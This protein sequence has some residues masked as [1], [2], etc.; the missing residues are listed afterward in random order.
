M[1]TQLNSNMLD[2]DVAKKKAGGKT[3]DYK[4]VYYKSGADF[5]CGYE[6]R[7]DSPDYTKDLSNA[8]HIGEAKIA[9]YSSVYGYRV[10]L[11]GKEV[12]QGTR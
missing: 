3:M 6:S 4:I 10:Y 12:A 8:I 9:T 1:S 5:R 11:G 7:Y 2:N